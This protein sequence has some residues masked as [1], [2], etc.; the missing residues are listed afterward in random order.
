M[1][2]EANEQK[3][4]KQSH[5]G[6]PRKAAALVVA[7]SLLAPSA[8]NA[9]PDSPPPRPEGS[10]GRMRT[11]GKP[12]LRPSG[13]ISEA[14]D[15]FTAESNGVSATVARLL[16]VSGDLARYS[17]AYET[18]DGEKS[19]EF[20]ADNNAGAVRD[21]FI[22]DERT[23]VVTENTVF[24]VMGR[25]ALEREDSWVTVNGAMQ[26]GFRCIYYQLPEDLRGSQENEDGTSSPRLVSAAIT[27]DGN[28]EYLWL[29]GMDGHLRVTPADRTGVPYAHMYLP[30]SPDYVL[31]DAGGLAL[32]AK[33]GSNTVYALSPDFGVRPS[34]IRSSPITLPAAAE[35][36]PEI[37]GNE[38]E[39]ILSFRNVEFVVIIG[40]P[41]NPESVII[42]TAQQ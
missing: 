19:F 22:G 10:G 17:M 1:A 32:I 13:R 15:G 24:V 20:L 28:G 34:V 21:I 39:R 33:T 16:Q 38:R 36:M 25:A 40:E 12:S 6:H 37:R 7:A 5:H 4:A 35:G 3:A 41:G 23:V 11:P 42:L 29:M 8:A 26:E 14:E 9:L 30:A 27:R 31:L 18:K 2:Q